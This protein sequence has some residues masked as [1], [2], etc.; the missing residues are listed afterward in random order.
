MTLKTVSLGDSRKYTI[1]SDT[2]E[3]NQTDPEKILIYKNNGPGKLPT[4]GNVPGV[5]LIIL[6]VRTQAEKEGEI[7]FNPNNDKKLFPKMC[8][9]SQIGPIF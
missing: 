8:L 1:D 9:L 7:I 5:S 6:S 2:G 3:I 4:I